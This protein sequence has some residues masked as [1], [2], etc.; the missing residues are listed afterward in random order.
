MH[1]YD[2]SGDLVVLAGS[3]CDS[4]GN[5]TLRIIHRR[6]DEFRTVAAFIKFE[7]VETKLVFG[8]PIKARKTNSDLIR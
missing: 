2:R 3:G 4:L 6:N 7:V 1:G 8:L 5:R